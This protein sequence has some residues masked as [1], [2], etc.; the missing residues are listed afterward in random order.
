MK[1]LA[2]AVMVLLLPLLFIP[3][4]G[5]AV[6]ATR[7]AQEDEAAGPPPWRVTSRLLSDGFWVS[8]A[9]AI[10]LLPFAILLNPLATGL[11]IAHVWSSSDPALASIHTHVLAFLILALPWGLV[12][13]LVMPHATARFAATGRPADLFNYADS[14]RGVARDFVTWNLVAA[15]LVTAWVIA[16]ASAGLL[17][18]GFLPGAFYAILVS[19]HATAALRPESTHSSTR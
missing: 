1:W 10:T 3:L 2:G 9:I 6:A 8:L 17:C 5:Y 12:T 11:S 16:F 4:L 13:L 19:A 15:A 18:V 7:A 14:L